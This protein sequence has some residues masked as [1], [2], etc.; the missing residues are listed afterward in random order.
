MASFSAST[1]SDGTI[2]TI[3]DTTSGGPVSGS[4]RSFV[5]TD[6]LGDPL[7]TIPLA[8]GVLTA[9]YDITVPQWIN[10]QFL[11][12]GTSPF[13]ITQ[14]YGFD[15]ILQVAYGTALVDG[16][17]C[18][19]NGERLD[20]AGI[21]AFITGYEFAYPIGDAV[22]WQSDVDAAYTLLQP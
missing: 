7:E 18:G 20:W 9:T 10:I 21:D 11:N 4:I 15:R 5:L 6:S 17:G 8:D 16:C 2:V 1:N 3:T 19:C 13:D 14:R 12:T 22:T